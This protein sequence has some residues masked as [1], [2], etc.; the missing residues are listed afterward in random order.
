MSFSGIPCTTILKVENNTGEVINCIEFIYNSDEISTKVKNIKP[1]ENKQTG[2][3]TLYDVRDL[4]MIISE[5]DK[6]YLIKSEIS[7]GYS[8][9]I[10]IAINSINSDNCEFDMREG[11]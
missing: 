5:V 1:N 6:K 8:N 7:Q 2:V 10:T 11:E 9:T 4:K 3:R